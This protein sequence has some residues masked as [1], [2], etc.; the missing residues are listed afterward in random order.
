[1]T[2]GNKSPRGFKAIGVFLFFGC[3]MASLAGTTLLW[4]GTVVD[5]IWLLNST[6]YK[7]LLQFGR[8]AGILFLLLGAALAVAGAG[9]FKRRVWGWRLAVAIIAIQALGDLVNAFRGDVA[10][11]AIGFAVAGALLFYLLRSDVRSAFCK[12]PIPSVS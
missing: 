12:R 9:W 8:A 11:G 2:L 4:K 10:K 3:V 6:A 1:M 7:Q 5:R